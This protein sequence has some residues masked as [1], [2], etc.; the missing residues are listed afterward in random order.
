MYVKFSGSCLRQDKI[1][2]NNGKTVNI[3]IVYD[4]KSSVNDFDPTLQNCLFRQI[5]LTKNS[6]IDK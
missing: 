5:K 2:F 3:C 4:L 1:T 6:D